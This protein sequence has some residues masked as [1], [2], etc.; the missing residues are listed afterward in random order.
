MLVVRG[1]YRQR[2]RA[3]SVL[4]HVCLSC[5]SCQKI[6]RG[7][8]GNGNNLRLVLAAG[9]VTLSLRRVSRRS[10]VRGDWWRSRDEGEMPGSGQA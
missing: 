10:F 6:G 1:K 3:R 8:G 7:L 5:L 4:Q 9:T 2:C